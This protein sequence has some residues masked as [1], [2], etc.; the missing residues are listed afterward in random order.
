MMPSW[1]A[2]IVRG[3]LIV[4]L[5]SAAGAQS[6]I[7]SW[8]DENG[9]LH[10]S[11]SQVPPEHAAGARRKV[12]LEQPAP[13]STRAHDSEVDL[14]QAQGRRYVRAV[15]EGEAGSREVLMVVDTGAQIS[16]IDQSLAEELDVSF[17]R[18]A[19]LVGVTGAA[20]GWIG[21]L[22]RLRIGDHELTQWPV[23]VGPMPGVALLGMDV[24]DRLQLSVGRDRLH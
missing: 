14:I 21:R 23:M 9:V 4:L 24:L 17:E 11:N 2:A 7:Y 20:R 6:V 3:A 15:L 12:F 22:R 10:F 8:Q 16:V 1:P 5:A 13:L 18:P 19:Q